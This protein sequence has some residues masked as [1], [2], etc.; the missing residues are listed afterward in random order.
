MSRR[1]K[2]PPSDEVPPRRMVLCCLGGEKHG[3]YVIGDAE[4]L[5]ELVFPRGDE[6]DLPEGIYQVGHDIKKRKDVLVY[7]RTGQMRAFAV[8]ETNLPY[9]AVYTE[10][11]EKWPSSIVGRWAESSQTTWNEVNPD[12]SE[13]VDKM[14]DISE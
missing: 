11:G 14:E 10:D 7:H 12:L 4:L 3:H 6:N 9:F 8:G 13:M 2:N 5:K 1:K